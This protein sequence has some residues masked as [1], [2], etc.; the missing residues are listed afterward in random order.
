MSVS[1]AVPGFVPSV[2]GLHFANRFPAGPTLRV[3]VL[4]PRWLGIGKIDVSE[5]G[6]EVPARF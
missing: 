5:Q 3:G 6:F 4:D 2:H 1:N